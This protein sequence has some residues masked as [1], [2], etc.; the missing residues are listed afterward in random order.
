[1]APVLRLWVPYW[2][3]RVALA[4]LTLKGPVWVEVPDRYRETMPEPVRLNVPVLLKATNALL[5]AQPDWQHRLAKPV[6]LL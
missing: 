6:P 3:R 2:K 5:V 4:L 1:L